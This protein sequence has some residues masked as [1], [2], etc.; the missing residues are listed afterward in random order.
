[1]MLVAAQSPN[2]FNNIKNGLIKLLKKRKE[3]KSNNKEV[4]YIDWEGHIIA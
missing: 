3:K 2:R 1:M 4:K